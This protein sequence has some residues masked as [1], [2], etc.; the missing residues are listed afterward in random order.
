MTTK[1]DAAIF[2]SVARPHAA[3]GPTVISL[4]ATVIDLHDGSQFTDGKDRVTLRFDGGDEPWNKLRFRAPEGA[5]LRQRY[6][7][8]LS[9][10]ACGEERGE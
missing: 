4:H 5:H 1:L 10:V 9:P 2:D 3:D 8:I 6:V 7:V